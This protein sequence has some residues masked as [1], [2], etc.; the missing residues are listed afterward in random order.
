MVMFAAILPDFHANPP[1]IILLISFVIL[2]L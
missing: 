1:S 2:L